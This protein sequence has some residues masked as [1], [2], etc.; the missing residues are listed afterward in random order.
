M[1][2]EEIQGRRLDRLEQQAALYGPQTEPSI[3][4]EIAELRNKVRPTRGD[5]RGSFVNSLDFDLVRTSVAAALVR[6]GIIEA[7]Q[8]KDQSSRW[9]RQL[10]HDFWMVA[11]TVIVVLTL[12]LQLTGH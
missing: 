11:I 1:D 6:I 7:N 10:I 3:L 8:A 4:I 2:V 12:I 5:Q 9:I